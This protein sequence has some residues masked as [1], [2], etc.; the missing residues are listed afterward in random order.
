M[1]V[2]ID[3]DICCH[4][5][6]I[7]SIDILDRGFYYIEISLNYGSSSLPI[8]P[9]GCFSA[10]ST[11]TSKVRQIEINESILLNVCHTNEAVNTFE[12]RS[13]L[14]RYKDEVHEL[15]E[16]CHWRLTLTNVDLTKQCDRNDTTI[17]PHCIE[18]LSIKF[19]LY[20]SH[21]VSHESSRDIEVTCI[22]PEWEVVSDQQLIIQSASS[23][24]HEYYPVILDLKTVFK[25]LS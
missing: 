4:L 17:L 22:D 13:F 6:F 11:L 21:A 25:S 2:S 5:G 16:G 14:V 9:V 12:T 24:L 1:E 19:V 3:L 7:K 10:A 15:N 23:G 18:D 8:A 20:R